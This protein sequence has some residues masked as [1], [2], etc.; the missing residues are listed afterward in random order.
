LCRALP[1]LLA[2]LLLSGAALADDALRLQDGVRVTAAGMTVYT[3]DKDA[4]DSGKS[5]CNG[6]C[7]DNWPAV[8]APADV[9]PPY[10]LVTRDDGA[11]QLAYR[12]RPLYL[13][14]GDKAAGERNGDN[15]KT[16]WHVVKD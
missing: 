9:A 10:S 12:G 5:V 16:I 7:A 8:P 4:A 1:A 6:P 13:F 2:G 3:F 14:K 15:F 11:R